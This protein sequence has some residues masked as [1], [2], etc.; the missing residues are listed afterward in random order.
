MNTPKHII[1]IRLSAMGDVAMTIPVLRAFV[2][3]HPEVRIT[4]VSKAF[5]KP[6]FEGI[7]NLTF[8]TAE[9]DGKHKGILGLY[10]LFKAL[11]ALNPTHIADLHN[12]LRSKIVRGCFKIRGFKVGAIDKGRPEKKA[13]TRAHNKVFKQLKT[14]HQRYADVFNGLGFEVDITNQPPLKKHPLNKTLLS[15]TGEKDCAWIGIAPFAAFPSKTYPLD[16][17]SEVINQLTAYNYTV[18]LFGGKADVP[19][20]EDWANRSPKVISVANRLGGLANEMTLISHLDLM[21]S[22]DSG[23]AHFAAMQQVKTITLWGSTHPYAGFAPF[24]Q[25]EAYCLLPD[26]TAYP[27]LPSSIYGNKVYDGYEEAMRSIPP[28]KIVATILGILE[29]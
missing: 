25:P 28:E 16:A 5:L 7:P 1:V 8:F 22:M 29:G 2:G 19:V 11:K 13:L 21:V 23:N 9:V 18:F 4:V 26:L 27:K 24:G 6:L 20:L 15:I 12:V 17:M 14:S 10:R 3:Q